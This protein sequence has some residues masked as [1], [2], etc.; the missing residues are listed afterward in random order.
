MT[1]LNK[2]TC[3]KMRPLTISDFTYMDEICTLKSLTECRIFL[4]LL[5]SAA[6]LN[7]SIPHQADVDIGC[8]A[9]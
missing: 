2:L 1:M 9:S 4:G 6:K 7:L 5:G 3:W 8:K